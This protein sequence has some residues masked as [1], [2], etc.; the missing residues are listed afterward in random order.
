[1][2]IKTEIRYSFVYNLIL[3]KDKWSKEEHERFKREFLDFEELYNQNIDKIILAIEK[4]TKNEKWQN[5]FIPIYL[6]S[7]KSDMECY[8][9]PLTIKTISK[10]GTK[11]NKYDLLIILIHEL[12]HNNLSDEMQLSRDFNKNE[13][14]V[15][16]ITK[17][18][19]NELNI[20]IKH[21]KWLK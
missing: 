2:K 3:N 10:D 16:V 17:K 5:T 7:N 21:A 6:I 11:K 19:C 8:S 14:Y 13:S 9:D 1:M 4:N 20:D 18:V 12:I 15:N